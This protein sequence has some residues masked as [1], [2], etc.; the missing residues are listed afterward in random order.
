MDKTALSKFDKEALDFMLKTSEYFRGFKFHAFHSQMK[1][2]DDKLK[3]YLE[4]ADKYG[5]A[6]LFHTDRDEYNNENSRPKYV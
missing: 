3:P 1:I 5:L 4:F 2:P 6:F